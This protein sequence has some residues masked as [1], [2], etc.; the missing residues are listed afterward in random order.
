VFTKLSEEK[1]L[2]IDQ[3]DGRIFGAA[4]DSKQNL[5]FSQVS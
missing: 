4:K 3:D 1:L 5:N 2:R